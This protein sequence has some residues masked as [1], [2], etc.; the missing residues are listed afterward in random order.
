MS[1]KMSR[2]GVILSTTKKAPVD[3]LWIS[4]YPTYFT[5][6]IKIIQGKKNRTLCE[7]AK[8]NLNKRK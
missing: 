2:H 5:F 4:Y 1:Y 3:I 6:P 8:K 7:R